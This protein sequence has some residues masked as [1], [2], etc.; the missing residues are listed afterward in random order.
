[1]LLADDG[2]FAFTLCRRDGAEYLTVARTGIERLCGGG[3]I[4]GVAPG[5]THVFE[6]ELGRRLN[7][8]QAA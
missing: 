2:L 3:A 1:M 4:P 5:Y 7:A 8:P 6:G